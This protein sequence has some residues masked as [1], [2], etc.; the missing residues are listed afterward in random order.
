MTRVEEALLFYEFCAPYK[1]P[2][3]KIDCTLGLGVEVLLACAV[4][5]ACLALINSGISMKFLVAAVSCMIDQQDNII[6]D[7]DNKQLLDS[8]ATLMFVFDIV[9]KNIVACHTTGTFSQTQFQESL[10]KCREASSQIFT[11]Y[12]DMVKKYANV[13]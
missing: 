12:K 8:K 3:M 10:L 4:N 2:S 11:Y 9:K 5:A 6:L 7:P 1:R 13:M